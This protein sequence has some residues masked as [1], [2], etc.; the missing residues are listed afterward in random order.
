MLS[1]SNIGVWACSCLPKVQ[2]TKAEVENSSDIF[3]GE[4]ISI[5]TIKGSTQLLVKLEVRKSYKGAEDKFIEVRTAMSSAACGV[6]VNEGETWYVFAKE[7]NGKININSCGRHVDLTKPKCWWFAED[8]KI[9]KAVKKQYKIQKK[10]IKKELDLV[11][12]IVDK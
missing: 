10:A 9:A 7:S 2:V 4:V 11:Q 12:S 8:K 6:S 3:I 1:L 5:D